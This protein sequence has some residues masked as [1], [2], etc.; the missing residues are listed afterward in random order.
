MGCSS[1]QRRPVS[2][3]YEKQVVSALATSSAPPEGKNHW[4]LLP[5]THLARLLR[6]HKAINLL[7]LLQ[8]PCL[9]ERPNSQK[10]NLSYQHTPC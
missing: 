7:S 5:I 8:H 9:L 2:C 4:I 6:G 10:T 1:W 3:W